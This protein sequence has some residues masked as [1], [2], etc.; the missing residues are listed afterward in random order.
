M[1]VTSTA[2]RPIHHDAKRESACS[3]ILAVSCAHGQCPRHE[4]ARSPLKSRARNSGRAG[5]VGRNKALGSQHRRALLTRIASS[6]RSGSSLL[7][8]D[9]AGHYNYFRDYDPAI[10][11]YVESDPLGLKVGLSTYGYVGGSPLTKIDPKGL[12]EYRYCLSAC[13]TAWGVGFCLKPGGPELLCAACFLLRKPKLI[14]ACLGAC[15]ANP[16]INCVGLMMTTCMT[17]CKGLECIFPS[18]G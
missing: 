4:L 18:E 7:S 2:P 6:R 16:T 12:I 9:R 14:S 3:R 5:H 10:G 15:T 17:V 1:C 11:R 8:D 13:F